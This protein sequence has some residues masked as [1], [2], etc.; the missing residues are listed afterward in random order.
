M[1]VRTPE[2][3][4]EEIADEIRRTVERSGG[5]ERTERRLQRTVVA[6]CGWKAKSDPRMASLQQLLEDSGVF[7][8][9]ELESESLSADSWITFSDR[10]AARVVAAAI[11]FGDEERLH[12]FVRDYYPEL[13]SGTPLEK[14]EFVQSEARID[15]GI[16]KKLKADM[17]FKR[18]SGSYVAIE[19]KKSYPEAGDVAQLANYLRLIAAEGYDVSG[20]LISARPPT[21]QLEETAWVE[22]EAFKTHGMSI[23]WYWYE[24][25][26]PLQPAVKHSRQE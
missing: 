9:P 1:A 12:G 5:L 26:I 15:Q 11:L 10:P 24:L 7:T 19:F 3:F 17:L 13:F 18:N 25:P 8:Y 4:V 2:R 6:L 21:S 23:D 16:T 20:A 22:I 14:L